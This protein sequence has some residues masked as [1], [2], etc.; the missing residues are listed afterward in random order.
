MI[1]DRIKASI[2]KQLTEMET[3]NFQSHDPY[4][5]LLGFF[6]ER[7]ELSRSLSR[8][9]VIQ[10]CK[11]SRVLRSLNQVPKIQMVKSAALVIPT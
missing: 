1:M 6:G 5:G 8:Q 11:R 2:E 7:V 9:I 4:S 10:G 3:A